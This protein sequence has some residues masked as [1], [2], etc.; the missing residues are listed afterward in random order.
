MKSDIYIF[1]GYGVISMS[2]HSRWANIKH[3]KAKSDVKKGKLFTKLVREIIV[4]AKLGGGDASA[5]PRLR[6]AVEKAKAV[7]LPSDNIERAIKKGARELEGVNY[8]EGA[9]E[10]YGPGGVAVL[11]N[12]MT[13]NK[14]RTASDI[15][16]AFT[17]SG[18]SL[19]QT[20]S[21][22]WMFEK[23]GYIT[24]DIKAVSE[25]KLME[26]AIEAGAED[27]VP[28][29]AD[30]VFEVYTEPLNLHKVKTSFDES[31]LKYIQA[32]ITML[33]KTFVKV[34]GK[35][36]QQVL[37]LMEELEDLDDVQSVYANFDMPEEEFQKIA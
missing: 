18:G 19:G 5:N 28:N 11:V 13:D 36:A 12:Y 8:E 30:G 17:S 10:G 16:H 23:K 21:V 9:Y 25:D 29:P 3:K 7:N 37:R 27:V 31:G 35:I 15:R 22:G 24:F 6:T 1:E 33:P 20:G 26:A 4:A 32:D 34:E 2:G 14:N